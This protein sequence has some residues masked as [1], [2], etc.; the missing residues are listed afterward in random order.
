MWLQAMRAVPGR[1]TIGFVSKRRQRPA[2]K[3][4]PR[5]PMSPGEV[6]TAAF[7]LAILQVHDDAAGDVVAGDAAAY[8]ML[9][10]LCL[11]SLAMLAGRDPAGFDHLLSGLGVYARMR[12]AMCLHSAMAGQPPPPL[13]WLFEQGRVH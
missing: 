1:D 12:S 2:D 13:Q 9:S 3:P 10:L 8:E 6:A 5:P 4:E 7:G 11:E